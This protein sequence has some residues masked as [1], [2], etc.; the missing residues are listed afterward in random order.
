[1]NLSRKNKNTL[2]FKSKLDLIE[3]AKRRL[4][5]KASLYILSTAQQTQGVC[6]VLTSLTTS[7]INILFLLFATR[8]YQ[9]TQNRCLEAN[10]WQA[11]PK[12]STGCLVTN[13]GGWSLAYHNLTCY[14]LSESGRIAPPATSVLFC[15]LWAI[16]VRQ[17]IAWAVWVPLS[18]YCIHR[19]TV[20][21]HFPF[22]V[23]FL[24]EIQSAQFIIN[25]QA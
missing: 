11:R 21:K 18:L 17:T 10:K 20:Y 23:V 24:L 1:M 25:L 8:W 12:G 16:S 4:D 5:W 2:G 13:S 19:I 15:R 3:V 22:F 14:L 6:V 7:L 9:K